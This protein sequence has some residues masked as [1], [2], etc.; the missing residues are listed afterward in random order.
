MISWCISR[1]VHDPGTNKKREVEYESTKVKE[2]SSPK[3]YV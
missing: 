3:L 1:K 2:T